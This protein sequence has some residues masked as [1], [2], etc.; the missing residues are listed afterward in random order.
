M[1]ATKTQVDGALAIVK[2]VGD[3]IRT[4]GRVP[5]GQLYAQVS[6]HMSLANYEKVIGV[7]VSAGVVRQTGAH[8]LIWVG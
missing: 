4:L 3:A 1:S 5:S 2:A 6:G 7:L 8:E